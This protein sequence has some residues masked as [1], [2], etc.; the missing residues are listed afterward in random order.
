MTVAT[1]TGKGNKHCVCVCGAVCLVRHCVDDLVHLQ[2]RD[3]DDTDAVIGRLSMIHES[4]L[5][6]KS[7]SSIKHDGNIRAVPLPGSERV[8]T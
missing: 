8:A 1:Q 3:V 7:S 5:S 6:R 2:L 4:S